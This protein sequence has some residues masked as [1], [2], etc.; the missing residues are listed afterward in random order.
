MNQDSISKK[1]QEYLSGQ[2][3]GAELLDFEVRLANDAELAKEVEF[4]LLEKQVEDELIARNLRAKMRS[5]DKSEPTLTREQKL[6]I[7]LLLLLPLLTGI[8]WFNKTEK[9]V[10]EEQKSLPQMEDTIFQ[11]KDTFP[12][13][14][15]VTPPTSPS[16]QVVEPPVNVSDDT[17]IAYRLMAQ[18]YF[19]SDGQFLKATMGNGT[20]EASDSAL[21]KADQ[22]YQLGEIDKAIEIVKSLADERPDASQLHLILGKLYF[23]AKDFP[24]AIAVLKPISERKSVFAGEAKW[25]L[26]LSYLA[27][28]KMNAQEFEFL[29]NEITRNPRNNRYEQALKIRENLK[30]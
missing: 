28:Y 8:W 29:L 6:F 14:P 18:A 13:I 17:A 26:L 25:N 19:E 7:A 10:I 11:T 5:F 20:I 9:T 23:E 1:I 24:R 30:R 3:S 15:R 22:Y 27:N 4:Q 2:L 12:K 16:A 21:Q